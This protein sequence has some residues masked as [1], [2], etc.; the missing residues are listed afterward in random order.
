MTTHD[1]LDGLI[2]DQLR[3]EAPGRA[4][5]GL[6]EATMG[7][8]DTTSQRRRR[9]FLGGSPG[10]LLAVAAVLLGAVVAGTQL[11]GLVGRG[12]DVGASPSATPS[13]EP[14]PTPVPESPTATAEP[15]ASPSASA[16]VVN[17]LVLRLVELSGP[18]YPGQLLPVVTIMEDG[19]VI[20]SPVP[21]PTETPS[22]LVRRLTPEGLSALREHIFGSGLLDE[23]A[24][25]E[26]E[27]RPGTPEP[28]GRGVTVYTFTTGVG[29]ELVT[30]NSVQWLGDEEE[31]AYYEASPERR[32]LDALARSLR[33][34]ESLVGADAWEGP[35]EPYAGTEYQLVLT[36]Y[37]DV[38]PYDTTDASEIPW[39]FDERLDEYGEAVDA[40]GPPFR[41]C[42]V[43]GVED[44][45]AIMEAL[46]ATGSTVGTDRATAASLDWAEGNGTVDVLLM[47]RMP[48]GFP[49]CADLAQ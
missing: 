11:P 9:G 2:R 14:T 42:G 20:W 26:P 21:P 36:P 8:I 22:L 23:T 30:V 47:P 16:E 32:E 33:D 24:A 7:R 12:P 34:P 27:L 29:G 43:I 37:P 1:D 3:A 40:A 28:P 39:P 25:H 5:A 48:D 19:T 6:L 18:T 4:P 44:A 38:P 41:R 45:S 49:T 31:A 46:G 15:P 13:A 10:R 35:A 17:G